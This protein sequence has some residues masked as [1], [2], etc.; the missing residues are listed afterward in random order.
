MYCS[1]NNCSD[2]NCSDNNWIV[3]RILYPDSPQDTV[4]G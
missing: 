3:L 4:S 1:D 2:N